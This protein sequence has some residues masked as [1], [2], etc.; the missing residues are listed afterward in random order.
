MTNSIDTL[1][2]QLQERH[3]FYLQQILSEQDFPSQILYE[4]MNY[5]LFPGGKRIRPL[6][7]YLVGDILKISPA[8]LDILAAAIE[9]IHTYSLIHDDLPAMDNDDFR[10]GKPSCH[11]AFPEGLAIL[12]G[13][14]LQ[15]YAIQILLQKLPLHL[16]PQQVIEIAQ[17]LCESSGIGGMISGQCFDLYPQYQKNS[18]DISKSL[19]N[20]KHTHDLKTGKL[21]LACINMSIAAQK[22]PPAFEAVTALRHYAKQLGFTYQIQDD[23]LDKYAHHD[24][25]GKKRSSDISNQKNTYATYYSHDALHSLITEHYQSTLDALNYFGDKGEPLRQ[26]TGLLLKR[27]KITQQL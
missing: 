3:N 17:I 13:D 14:A 2:T 11:K 20:L 5:A 16:S 21:I 8:C 9:L 24:V 22:A 26:F 4:A 7:I 18:L 15:T 10:R 1:I 19:E 25:L 27:D 12:A 6:L 23:Y